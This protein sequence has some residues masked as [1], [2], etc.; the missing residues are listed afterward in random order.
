MGEKSIKGMMLVVTALDGAGKQTQTDIL[1]E[2]M[3]KKFPDRNVFKMS[4]PNYGS[5]GASLVEAYLH[6]NFDTMRDYF[7]TR[8]RIGEFVQA[9]SQFYA[10]DRSSAFLS[11]DPKTNKSYLQMYEE[12]AIII[13]DRY[14]TCNQLHQSSFLESPE[15]IDAYLTYIKDFEVNHMAVP[16]PDVVLYLDVTPEISINNVK[17]RNDKKDVVDRDILE[18]IEHLNAV[19][20]IKDQII[21]S[22]KWTIVHC[23][24]Y[25]FLQP[26]EEVARR[27]EA[28]IAHTPLSLS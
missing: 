12:G 14:Y 5:P 20:A 27:I 8:G 7:K 19:Y 15:E 26:I 24:D 28:A 21:Q 2:K 11:I 3:K 16:E 6:G 25:G 10:M 17:E 13:C 23:H 1:L 9:I 18:N 22:Q 4:F